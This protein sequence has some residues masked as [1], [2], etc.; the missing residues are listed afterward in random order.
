[1]KTLSI[2]IV[3]YNCKEY[4]LDC[5]NSI[6]SHPPK[7]AE[8]ELIVVDNASSDGTVDAIREDYPRVKLVPNEENLG[9][10]AGCNIGFEH[11]TGEYVLFLNPDVV[12]NETSF[13]PLISFLDKTPDAGAVIGSMVDADGEPVPNVRIVPTVFDLLI[14]RKSF[15]AWLPSL[16]K[17][18]DKRLAIPRG[19]AE[20]EAGGGGYLLVRS[21]L[22]RRVGMMDTRF[23][24]FVEDID[25]SVRI[26]EAGYKIYYLPDARIIHHWGGSTR[27]HMTRSIWYHHISLFRFFQKYRHLR[28][29]T[30]VIWFSFTVSHF[31]LWLIT[32][33][34]LRIARR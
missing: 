34:L 20:I 22:Y 25:L 21:E 24:L 16:G 11:S 14:S 17:I 23:F 15:I 12:V 1:M 29:P 27:K 8:L 5:L 3:S 26:R 30:D 6:F 18:R 7:T 4:L 19:V 13:D 2:I 33:R 28:F 31:L 10:A 9:F 32:N